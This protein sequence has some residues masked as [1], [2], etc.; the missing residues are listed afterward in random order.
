MLVERWSIPPD[1]WSR[2][3]ITDSAQRILRQIP[4]RAAARGLHV[5]DAGSIVM[6][7]LWWLLMWE[8]KVGLVALQRSGVDRFELA[9]KLDLFLEETESE[10][11]VAYDRQRDVLVLVKTQEPYQGWDFETLLEPLLRQ[12]EQ[13][14][15]ELGH[16]YVGSEH[17]VL[18]IVR[19]ADPALRPLLQGH[20]VSYYRVREAVVE[21]LIS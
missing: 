13:E 4:T 3:H 9:R 14:A 18:A 17:L 21:L 10:H 1:A 15:Q 2:R 20:G 12:A 11:P 19:M 8:R 7:A 6:L 16:T 5:V